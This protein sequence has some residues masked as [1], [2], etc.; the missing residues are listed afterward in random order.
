MRAICKFII[1]LFFCNGLILTSSVYAENIHVAAATSLTHVLEEIADQFENETDHVVKL[2][3]SSSGN[4]TRQIIQGA[5]FKLF[6]SADE[7]YISLLRKQGLTNGDND[8]YGIGRLVLYVPEGSNILP[9]ADLSTLANAI[10]DGELTRLAIANPEHAPYGFI[11]KQA[12]Q[13][14]GIWET[15]MPYL[16]TGKSASQTAQFALS[17]AVDAALIPYSLAL[18]P[19]LDSKGQYLLINDTLYNP[20]E[21]TMVLIKGADRAAK[22]LYNFILGDKARTIIR[23]HGFGESIGQINQTALK[24]ELNKI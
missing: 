23:S 24:P 13:N 16:V 1:C 19:E 9:S 11:A 18:R 22:E 21:Q 3:F 4:L 6:L 8:I 7:S 20:L 12:L 15:I 10:K 17:N 14:A 2:S 5:P